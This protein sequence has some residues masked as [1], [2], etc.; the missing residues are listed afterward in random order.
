MNILL[1]LVDQWRGDALGV[2]QHPVVETPHLD[3]LAQRGAI[4]SCAYSSS[5]SCISARASLFTGLAPRG[6]VLKLDGQRYA[7]FPAGGLVECFVP[8]R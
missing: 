3:S 1:I 7:G 5:P 2:A 6:T 8:F 4:F